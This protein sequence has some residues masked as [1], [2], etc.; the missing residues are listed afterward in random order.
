MDCTAGSCT[1]LEV[2]RPVACTWR[3]THLRLIDERAPHGTGWWVVP[4]P[5]NDAL[6]DLA[7]LCAVVA[8][9]RPQIPYALTAA[10][11]RVT[12]DGSFLLG[13]SHG[14]TCASFVAVL[15]LGVGV[16]LVDMQSWLADRDLARA[17]ED[18]Q[19][20]RRLAEHLSGRWPAHAALVSAEVGCAR[21]R[22]EEVAAAS[23]VSPHPLT[24]ARG[25]AAARIV[26][27]A[28]DAMG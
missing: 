16:R 4:T 21:L 25:V 8:R 26:Q 28:I 22:P 14:L 17:E 20:Q 23:G 11:A 9:R 12:Q 2:A 5:D 13:G 10:D 3:G 15:F 1:S 19:A 6:E 27:S 18:E 24:L 7:T